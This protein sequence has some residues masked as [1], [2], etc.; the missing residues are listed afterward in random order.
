V[1]LSEAAAILRVTVRTAAS[2]GIG[3]GHVARTTAVAAQLAR[4]GADVRWAC[5]EATV[6]YLVERGVRADRIHVLRHAATA[7]RS[8]EAEATDAAQAEDARE[9]LALG[10]ADCALVDSYQLGVAW[11][12]TARAAGVRVAAFDDLAE[13]PVEADLVINAAASPGGY[14]ALAPNARVLAGLP[15][16]ITGDP[17]RP[18]AAGPGT[19]LL[20]FGAADPGNLTEATLRALAELRDAQGSP[21]PETVIQLGSGA[22]GRPKVAELVATLA[23]ATFA[24]AGPT[25]PGAP[26]IAIG[27]A[28]VGLLERMQAGVPSVVVVAA[29]NQR[30]LADAAKRSGAAVA[31]A[32]V[33][34]ACAEALRL[35]ADPAALARMS[36]AGR[37]AVDGRGAARV[38]RELNRLAGVDLRHATLRDAELLH[39][40]RND[41]SVRAVSHTTDEIPWETHVRWLESSLARGDRHVLVA[42]RRGRPLG[43]LRFDVSG[44]RATVSI[45]VDPALHGSGLG[46][47][48]L[49]AGDAWLEAN[50]AR[51]RTCRAEIRDGNDASVRAFLA[52][53]YL[54]GTDSYERPVGRRTEA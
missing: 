30:A 20:A 49:D 24:T 33:R 17:S 37:A 54:P 40:W 23:W 28:G 25:S 9:T 1:S 48:I 16:A 4:I 51:V 32:D 13:R 18:P 12:R 50:D 7:G 2:A 47:A 38:A 45:A 41:P 21:F 39:R 46:P 26:A 34:A 43:T 31:V 52:A 11:Q 27:A 3:A 19:L 35:L 44:D 15:Y 42:E 29:P 6:A 5:D 22:S 8:G 14:D 36:A 10:P 53:G